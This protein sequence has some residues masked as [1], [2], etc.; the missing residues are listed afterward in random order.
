[1]ASDAN[2]RAF[3]DLDN[4][5]DIAR[6]AERGLMD[7]LFLA[8]FAALQPESGRQPRWTLDPMV[9]LSALA[10]VTDHV[11][12]VCSL[13]TTLNEPYHVAR[14]VAS[15]DHVSRGR[16][17]WNVV[18]STRPQLRAQLR[19]AGP[20]P[21]RP[22]GTAAP[23]SSSTWSA[24]CGA[25]GIPTRWRSTPPPVPSSTPPRCTPPTMWASSSRWQARCRFPRRPRSSQCCSRRAGPTPDA[26]SPRARPTQCS[27]PSHAGVGAPLPGRPAAAGRRS[28]AATST[29]SGSSPACSSSWAR[30][31]TRP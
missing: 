11:G 26:T 4:Y 2:R 10:S 28:W 16:A 9:V 24:R 1:M 23:A 13:S 20:A 12:L 29:T 5:R 7:A 18:T 19:D 30:P 31:A 14:L 27:P 3:I 21:P 25:A 17:G 6:L 22:T 15:L 8:D